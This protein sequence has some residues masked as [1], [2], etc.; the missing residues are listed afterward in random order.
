MTKIGS[1]IYALALV[2]CLGT[3]AM[4]AVSNHNAKSNASVET[5]LAS[6]GAFRDGLYLGKLAAES[7]QAPRPAIGRWSADQDRSM[8]AAGYRRG[9][10][11]SLAS[12]AA[13]A[14][15]AQSTE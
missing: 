3:T 11:E 15:L 4:L 10:S 13:N 2:I 8:F 14:A 7:G 9:Y 12:A 1:Y 6:D 5:A